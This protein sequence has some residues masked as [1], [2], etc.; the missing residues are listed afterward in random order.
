MSAVLAHNWWAV[1]LRGVLGIVFGL[2]AFYLPGA[3]ILS[4]VFIF[5]AYV[6]V[7][8]V[9][10]II[11]AIRAARQGER[12]GLLVVEGIADF[13]VGALSMLWP[14][15]TALAFVLIIACWSVVSGSLMVFAAFNLNIEHGRWWLV[16]SG[17]LSVVFGVLLIGA[18]LLGVIVVAWWLGAYAFAF[19]VK[20]LIL[21]FKLWSHRHD[22][23]QPAMAQ[24]AA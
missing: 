11:S 4:L 16:L 10:A 6:I 2:I 8:G 7:D 15:L 9:F 24:G 20:L 19:G 1:A 14:G 12:W 21:A 13:L 18:P 3:T 23:P 5:A 22:H 17:A